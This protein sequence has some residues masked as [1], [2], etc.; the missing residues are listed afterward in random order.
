MI[1]WQAAISAEDSLTFELGEHVSLEL[2]LIRHGSFEMGSPTD[3]P[4]RNSDETRH[5][6]VLSRDYYI[7]R[8]PVTLAQFDRFVSETG[9]RTEAEAGRSGGF[10]WDG[11]KLKQDA[12]FSWRNTGFEQHGDQPVTMVSYADAMEFCHWLSRKTRRPVTL[13]NEAQWEYACR[14][15]TATAWHNGNDPTRAGE[16]AW[17]KPRAE[18]ATHPVESVKPNAWGLYIGGNV[19]EW[20]MD[21]YS[22]YPPGPITDPEQT[23]SSLSDKPR[24]VLRG[25]SWLREVQHTRS[26][27][28]YRNDPGSRNAD[29]GFRIVCSLPPEPAPAPKI[30]LEEPEPK[31]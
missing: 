12:S 29:N 13:P 30:L 19:N 1:S 11:S 26:A 22:P 21:W 24:R 31:K 8:S 23:D 14:A 18:N 20:C 16:I 2:I 5:T 6:V 3:E 17:F 9:Y 27:A 4:K 7:G 15:G 25:G 10:G 28:R